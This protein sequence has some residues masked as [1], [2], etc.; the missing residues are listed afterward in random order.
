MNSQGDVGGQGLTVILAAGAENGTTTISGDGK[1]VI[2]TSNDGYEGTDTFEYTIRDDTT[3]RIETAEVT[4]NVTAVPTPSPDAVDDTAI[5]T[6]GAGQTV[7]VLANDANSQGDVGGQGLTVIL[8]AG[9]ENGTTTISG[10]GKSVIYTSNDGYEGTDTFEYTIRDDTTGRT[11][12]A[13]VTV[14]V[15]AVPTPSPD[16]V[17]DT[18]I[19]TS[20]AG[21][22]VDV[23]ANDANSQGDVGGQGLTVILADGANNGTTVISGDGKSVI[24]TSNAGYEGTD[25]FE[26]TIRDDTTGRTEAAEVTVNVSAVPTPSPDAV[27]DTAIA[28]SGAGQTVDVLAN[29]VNSQGDVG[30]QG[31]TVILADGANNGTTVISGDG[32]SVIYTS[33][34]GYE[35]TDTFEYT[36]RDDTTGRT[37]AAEVTVNVTAV[38]PVPGPDAMDDTSTGVVGEAQVIDVLANDDEGVPGNGDLIITSTSGASNGTVEIADDGKSVTYTPN[39]GFEGSDSFSYLIT[40]EETGKTDMATVNVTVGDPGLLDF[41]LADGGLLGEVTGN[42]GLLGDITGSDGVLGDLL[43]TGGT[44]GDV[45]GQE[46]LVG[47]LTGLTLL[48][49]GSGDD[50][51]LDPLVADNGALGELT[52]DDGLLADVTGAAGL[53]GDLVTNSGILGDVTGIDGLVGDLT[54][55]DTLSEPT[56]DAGDGAGD[57]LLDGLLGGGEGDGG[58]LDGL[59]GGGEGDGGLL[60]GLLGG[61]EGDGGLLDGLLGGGEGDGGLLDGLLG[62]GE[63]DGGLLDG[64]LGGGEGGGLLDGVLGGGEGGGLLDGVLG[65]DGGLL[66]G[67]TGDDGMAA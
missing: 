8:A 29:D 52:G 43:G 48:G 7:D 61:G 33:N 15:T 36:I 13:E 24:Y 27:D 53:V 31:L 45:G 14:N 40:E 25:T 11:E 28:T 46:G 51:I 10:D 22:A 54:G 55:R 21:Q 1:S 4:V 2:Y 47:D 49:D 9:A 38:P 34:D 62:G 44:L 16:A 64:L 6:S 35:G 59:L 50:A 58:L 3:G 18:A 30:G 19:A 5:A 57:G 63:G 37:E 26:Y 41:L 32:K 42:S 17:D 66:G 39:D 65:G 12:A 60:D 67:L 23:L 20:G 56:G